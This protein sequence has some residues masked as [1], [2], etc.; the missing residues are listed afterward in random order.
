VLYS[1]ASGLLRSNRSALGRESE[2]ILRFLDQDAI[3][4]FA[5]YHLLMTASVKRLQQVA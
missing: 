2:R 3:D 4:S 5:A 1:E